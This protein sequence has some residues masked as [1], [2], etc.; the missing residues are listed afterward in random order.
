VRILITNDDG[1]RAPGIAALATAAA[2]TGHDVVVVAPLIDYS[3]ASAAV[4]PI[5]SRAGVDY[6]SHVIE[7]LGSIPT[8]GIDGPPALA[9]ILAC[10]GGFGPRPDMVLSGVNHGINVGRSAMHS[11]TVGAA[12]T[13]A[14]FGLR[15]LAVS[16]RWGD[17]PVPWET[18]AALAIRLVPVLATAPPG[19][20][21]NLNTPNVELSQLRGL[22]HGRLGRGGTIRSAVHATDSS[23]GG[24]PLPHVALP[25]GHTGTLRLDLTAPGSSVRVQP[26][27]DAGLLARDYASLTPLVGVREAG[28]DADE[29]LDAALEALY[30]VP[31]V[32]PGSDPGDVPMPAADTADGEVASA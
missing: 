2:R 13:G 12:L 28:A 8:Y 23:E 20:T 4:G 31:G 30:A 22:R 18:A 26:D 15:C 27:T 29:V 19:T 17:D 14:H 16:I 24:V 5:H 7:G 1:V 3:G 32:S 6:E 21:F 11:G 10:V 9:V 25:P